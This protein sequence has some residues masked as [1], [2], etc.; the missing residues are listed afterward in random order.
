MDKNTP[1]GS[2]S[3]SSAPHIVTKHDTKWTMMNVMIALLP[4]LIM[5]TYMFGGR[6]IILTIVCVAA[7]VFCEWAYEKIMKKPITIGDLSACVT[8]M[9]LAFNLPA[10]FPYW[11]AV[12]GCITAIVVVKQ[13]FGG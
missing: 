13:L 3:V 2:L 12:I 4:A 5:S 7:C 8:G 11:M 9:L 1:I 10:N 6:V